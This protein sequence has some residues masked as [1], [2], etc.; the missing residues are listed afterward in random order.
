MPRHAKG[1]GA[2]LVITLIVALFAPALV[3]PRF[4]A[5]GFVYDLDQVALLSG[6]LSLALAAIGFVA[7]RRATPERFGTAVPVVL[8]CWLAVATTVAAFRL[9]SEPALADA[10]T[11][12][13]VA[14]LGVAA[15]VH[16]GSA[17]VRPLRTRRG[18][19]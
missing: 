12:T 6:T 14:L 13:G 17:L 7:T 18:P 19:R 3:M 15:L 4:R 5:G 9:L 8:A 16:I 2:L 10:G 11:V 1:R